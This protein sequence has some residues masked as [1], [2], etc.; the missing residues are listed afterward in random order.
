MTPGEHNRRYGW[1]RT[2]EEM[3]AMYGPLLKP[4]YGLHAYGM[5]F[6][7]SLA[8]YARLRRCLIEAQEPPKPVES[9]RESPLGS[10]HQGSEYGDRMLGGVIVAGAGEVEGW[11]TL[12]DVAGQHESSAAKRPFAGAHESKTY[13][14]RLVYRLMVR[15]FRHL[16]PV[17]LELRV[18]LGK[19]Q[20]R[21]EAGLV[22]E[23]GDVH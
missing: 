9:E 1:N 6:R 20:I 4:G 19:A 14:A 22:D 13:G 21:V 7:N 8:E 2:Q 5:A 10:V 11:K 12:D 18:R 17:R 23:G 3:E 16:A 15:V